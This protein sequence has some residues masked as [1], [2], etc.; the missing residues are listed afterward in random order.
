MNTLH[1]S[2]DEKDNMSIIIDEYLEENPNV[3]SLLLSVSTAG[4]VG[5]SVPAA[6]AVS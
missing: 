6:T 5:A 4:E 3:K 1:T 2:E